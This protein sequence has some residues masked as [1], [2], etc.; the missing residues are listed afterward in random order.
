MATIGENLRR[1]RMSKGLTQAQLAAPKYTHAHVSS[2]E[3]GRRHPSMEAAEHFEAK[4]GVDVEELQ[5][6]LSHHLA[7]RLELRLQEA[8]VAL[9]AGE[10]KTAPKT[11]TGIAR[12]ARQHGLHLLESSAEEAL[13][14]WLERLGEPERGLQ[15]YE[16]AEQILAS[17]PPTTRVDAVA[18]KAR[19][20]QALGDNRYAIHVLETLLDTI[21]REQLTDPAAL[22]RVHA[23]LVDAYLDAGL[24]KRAGASAAELELLAVHVSD[25]LRIAQMHM[26]VAHQH[27]YTGRSNHAKE[28]LR[29]AEDAFASVRLQTELAGAYLAMGYVL[30]REGQVEAA[31]ERLEL[32]LRVFEDTGNIKDQIRTLNELGRVERLEGNLVDAERLLRSSISLLQDSDTPILAWAHRELGH[33]L[34]EADPLSSEKSYRQAIELFE[35]AEQRVEVAVSYRG[36]GDLLVAQGRGTEGCEAYRTGIVALDD[37]V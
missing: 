18:G 36:L 34:L 33:V 4:L 5:T 22:T 1:L 8:R 2:I 14:L 25:P 17:E 27:L 21:E 15:H 23:S 7:I 13:G 9:S 29:R 28:S 30:S 6:G 10:L 31:R 12:E 16:R 11:L 32:A 3:A 24:H 19:C 20:F 26:N 37:M 35:R